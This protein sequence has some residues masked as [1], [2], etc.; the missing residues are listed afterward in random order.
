MPSQTLAHPTTTGPTHARRFSSAGSPSR[1]REG[2]AA[3]KPA[4]SLARIQRIGVV[5]LGLIWLVDGLL[6]FQPYMFAKTFITGVILPNASGQPGIIGS[7]ITWIA[8]V[9]KPHVALFNGFAATLQV[10]IGAG[11][12]CR[13]TVKPALLAS[14]AWALGIWVTGEGVGMIFTGTASPLTGAPGAALLYILVGLM[15]WPRDRTTSEHKHA[16][17]A[18]LGLI[19]ER[20]TRLAWGALWLGSAALWLF[21]ANDSAGAVHDAIAGVP[22]GAGWLSGVLSTA[23]NAAAGR[24]TIVAIAVAIV[25][26][27][28]GV[29]V[30]RDWHSRAFLALAV[31]MSLVYW[32]IG[33]GLGGLFTGQATDIGT[34]PL[35]ILI[36]SILCALPKR[37]LVPSPVRDS[38]DVTRDLVPRSLQLG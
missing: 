4:R 15:C 27:A 7:P 21:P 38:A 19:G 24:G 22:S 5:A 18:E 3:T 6:Q 17:V 31:A 34:A 16:G 13:R 36:A 28:I 23:A 33:Q 26:G 8:G 32:V 20:N 14:F 35:V 29:A 11:L 2:P 37:T 25:S 10:L 9:L 30:W 1:G 12:L